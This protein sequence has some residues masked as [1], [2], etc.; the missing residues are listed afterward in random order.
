[1]YILADWVAISIKH[2]AFPQH[3]LHIMAWR[4]RRLNRSFFE[5]NVHSKKNY[6]FRDIAPCRWSYILTARHLSVR[7]GRQKFSLCKTIAIEKNL[8]GVGGA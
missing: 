4:I 3:P 8:G 6:Y 1:M 5:P 2:E 7:A